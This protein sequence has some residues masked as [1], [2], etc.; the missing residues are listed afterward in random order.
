M[1]VID[2]HYLG[3][4]DFCDKARFFGKSAKPLFLKNVNVEYICRILAK[5]FYRIVPSY[6]NT[7]FN[8]KWQRNM[9]Y[10]ARHM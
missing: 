2:E 3:D 4:A 5:R 10:S 7:F 6:L 9:I 1:Q 8:S